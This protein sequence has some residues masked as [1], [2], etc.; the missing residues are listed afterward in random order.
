MKHAKRF[1]QLTLV[2]LQNVMIVKKELDTSWKKEIPAV[3][4]EFKLRPV[5]TEGTN[6]QVNAKRVKRVYN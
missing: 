1:G 5:P 3:V 6:G 4:P 2:P